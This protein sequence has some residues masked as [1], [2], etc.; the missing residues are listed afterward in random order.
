MYSRNKILFRKFFFLKATTFFVD[1]LENEVVEKL[2]D[3]FIIFGESVLYGI[4]IFIFEEIFRIF[5]EIDKETDVEDLCS[6]ARLLESVSVVHK[7]LYLADFR[8]EYEAVR[9]KVELISKNE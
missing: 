5:G 9:N 2:L 7:L 6:I 3:H 1:I 4:G 8:T